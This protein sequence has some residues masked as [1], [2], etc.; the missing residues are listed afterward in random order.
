MS[1]SRRKFAKE[2]KPAAVRRLEA[3]A[4][5]AEVARAC[6]INSNML[7][8]WRR[9]FRERVDRAFPGHGRSKAEENRVPEL[10]R[11]I[12]EQAMEI[13]FLKR[14]LWRVEE[15]RMLQAIEAA[16]PSAP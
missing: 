14:V 11:K 5:V 15:A 7:H 2:F 16:A 4:A 3:S 12:G 6:E 10:E 1:L 13:D 8:R 9:E